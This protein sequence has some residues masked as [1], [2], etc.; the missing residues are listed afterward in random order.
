MDK[1]TL[2]P[3]F[4][5]V[6]LDTLKSFAQAEFTVRFLK[7]H[8][9]PVGKDLK[10]MWENIQKWL[11]GGDM[12]RCQNL[13]EYTDELKLWGRQR[14]FLYDIRDEHKD[15]LADLSDPNYVRGRVGDAYDKPIYQWEAYE[16]FLARV[17][18]IENEHTGES[19]LVFKIIEIR[20]FDLVIDGKEQTFEDRS[21]N[22]FIVNLKSGHAELRLQR[23]P[24]GAQKRFKEELAI[25]EELLGKYLDFDK[26]RPIQLKPVMAD[27]LRGDQY[28][29]NRA[30]FARSRN[31]APGTPTLLIVFQRIFQHASPTRIAVVREGKQPILGKRRLHFT[32]YAGNNS[33]AFDGTAHPSGI[34][35]ILQKIVGISRGDVNGPGPILKRGAISKT[36]QSLEDQPRAQAVVLS[37]GAIAASIIWIVIEELRE[38]I[39]ESLGD[40]GISGIPLFVLKILAEIIWIIIYY[41][42]DRVWQSF[43]ALKYM[44]PRQ[45]WKLIKEARQLGDG[46]NQDDD[47]D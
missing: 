19:E 25:F 44:S 21:T 1:F 45:L 40:W 10:T 30:N 11:K 29:I 41:G 2:D 16:P 8:E 35:E 9:V 15:Y 47:E 3:K 38:R 32:M 13:I 4:D 46:D 24:T 26:F 14:V 34:H 5:Q 20:M 27:L 12:S 7:K 23:L 37:A 22:F 36:Y 18:H 6:G 33:V 43:T 42:S 39:L 28:P 17:K 31:I